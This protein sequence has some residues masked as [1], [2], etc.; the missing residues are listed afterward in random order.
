MLLIQRLKTP[1]YSNKL[2]ARS[3]TFMLKNSQGCL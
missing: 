1:I 2:I 3:S